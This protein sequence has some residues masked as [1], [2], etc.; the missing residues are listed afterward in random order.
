MIIKAKQNAWEHQR[1]SIKYT[2]F[3][4]YKQVPFQDNVCKSDLFI[5]LAK[6]VLHTFDTNIQ[7]KA[8]KK[9]MWGPFISVKVYNSNVSKLGLT[10]VYKQYSYSSPS[11]FPTKSHFKQF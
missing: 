1:I 11:N 4:T 3:L 10:T 7:H 9:Q 2:E 5:S 6:W 8:W